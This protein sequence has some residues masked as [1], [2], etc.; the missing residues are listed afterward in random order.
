MISHLDSALRTH[1]VFFGQSSGAGAS[2]SVKY[3]RAVYLPLISLKW[4]ITGWKHVPP[5]P[6][7]CQSFLL[8][9]GDTSLRFVSHCATVI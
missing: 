5:L 1:N 9:K 4:S 3:I 6:F 8:L 7:I 2:P